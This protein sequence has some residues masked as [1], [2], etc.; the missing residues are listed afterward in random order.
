[1]V[2]KL[3]MADISYCISRLGGSGQFFLFG[4]VDSRSIGLTFPNFLPCTVCHS[5]VLTELCAGNLW[6]F[7]NAGCG[8]CISFKIDLTETVPESPGGFKLFC[9]Q[10]SK[11]QKKITFPPEMLDS[12]RLKFCLSATIFAFPPQF[13]P[14]PERRK[15]S[16][17]EP[18]C[19]MS[20]RCLQLLPLLISTISVASTESH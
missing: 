5:P 20:M 6:W 18:W 13:L 7:Y 2:K 17:F 14:F 8:H 12:K 19:G 4:N 16:K 15:G 9:V 3:V 1:M 10:G 11:L